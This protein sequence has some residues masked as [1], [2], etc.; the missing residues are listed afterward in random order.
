MSDK[1][2]PGSEARSSEPAV[3]PAERRKYTQPDL[4]VVV[5]ALAGQ[6][7]VVDAALVQEIIR[8]VDLLRVESAPD[9]IAGV[10]R[11]R[12]RIIPIVDLRKRLGLSARSPTVESCAIIVNLSVGPVGFIVDSASQLL[13]VQT[14]DFEVLSPVIVGVDQAHLQGVA[15]LGNRLLVMLD[16]ERLLTLDEQRQ[17]GGLDT[18]R[19][20]IAEQAGGIESAPETLFSG[21]IDAGATKAGQMQEHVGLRRLLAFELSGELYGVP[22]TDVAEVCELLPLM[23]LPNVPSH[24]LGL[25]NLRGTVLPVIDLRLEFC[26]DPIEPDGPDSRLIVLKGQGYSVAFRVDSLYGLARLPQADFQA[27]PPDVA[28]VVPE[29]YGQVAS[30]DGRMLIELDVEKLVTGAAD[31]AETS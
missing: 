26:L 15:H 5:F 19:P 25:I 23:P 28:R 14:H 17:L 9:Y 3:A 8:L 30:L 2:I 6:E 10:V 13:W 18:P 12:G 20:A 31:R 22:A 27:A 29:Y 1:R 24:V 21:E 4:R 11:R 16:L 7:Y